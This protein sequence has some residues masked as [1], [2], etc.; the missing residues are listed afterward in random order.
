MRILRFFEEKK[1]CEKKMLLE[2]VVLLMPT[3]VFWSVASGLHLLGYNSQYNGK[4]TIREMITTQ[5]CID[6]LQ[7]VSSLPRLWIDDNLL[8]LSFLH[9]IYGIAA[10][11]FVEYFSHRLLHSSSVLMQFHKRHHRLV[12]VHTL[13]AYFNDPREVMFTGTILG[14]FLVVIGGL[15]I[16]EISIVASVGTVFTIFDH[17]PSSHDISRHERHHTSGPN[18][19]FS[20]PF[21]GFYDFLF[22]TRHQDVYL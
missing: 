18:A 6:C 13:G 7:F 22:K 12:P 5:L 1:P 9:I 15:S 4:V 17:C 11:D 3:I 8:E 20:Q 14:F 21:T 19:D 2:C 10:I 16:L